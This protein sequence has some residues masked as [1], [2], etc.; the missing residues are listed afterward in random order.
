MWGVGGG[1]SGLGREVWW[2]AGFLGSMCCRVYFGGVRG[3]GDDGRGGMA[4]VRRRRRGKNGERD[5][6]DLSVS[7]LH[8]I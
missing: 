5:K 6:L 7:V 8:Y 2:V 1:L 4:I 3:G